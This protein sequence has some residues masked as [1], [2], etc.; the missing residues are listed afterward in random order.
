MR[1]SIRSDGFSSPKEP[2]RNTTVP[3]VLRP[4]GNRGRLLRIYMEPEEAKS[5]AGWN[6]VDFCPLYSAISSDRKSVV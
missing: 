5:L 1:R 2:V 3:A 4:E 6:I